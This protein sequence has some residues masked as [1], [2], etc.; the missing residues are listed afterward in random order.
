MEED[1]IVTTNNEP[2]QMITSFQVEDELTV[3]QDRT[4]VALEKSIPYSNQYEEVEEKRMYE[5]EAQDEGQANIHSMEEAHANVE[6]EIETGTSSHQSQKRSHLPF[7]VMMLQS[8][9]KK[10]NVN[11]TA[12]FDPSSQ[13]KKM[14][15]IEMRK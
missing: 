1:P 6:E 13:V 11:E 7:N 9:K 5:D 15:F 12:A 3:S 10:L 8:D 4:A 2:E 14:T